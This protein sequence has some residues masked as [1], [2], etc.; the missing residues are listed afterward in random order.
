M[1][2]NNG[3][4]QSLI[5]TFAIQ[6]FA[7]KKSTA[8]MHAMTSSGKMVSTDSILASNVMNAIQDLF[9]KSSLEE[10]EETQAL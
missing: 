6:P 9:S 2:Q 1:C 4:L 10:Q 7:F 8:R 3:P 5:P